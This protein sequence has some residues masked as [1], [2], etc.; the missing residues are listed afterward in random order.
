MFK[1]SVAL[2]LMFSLMFSLAA[3]GAGST[4]ATTTAAG[5]TVAE[6]TTEAEYDGIRLATLKGPTGM[7]MAKLICDYRSQLLSSKVENIIYSEISTISDPTMIVSSLTAG[8]ADIAA[9]PLNLAASLYNKT[10]GG[11][12]MLAINTLGVLYILEK[13]NTIKTIADLKDKTIYATG[14]GSTP[15]YVLNYVLKQNGLTVGED[16]FVEFKAEHSELTALAASGGADICMLPEPNVTTAMTKNKDL[17]VAINMTDEWSAVC[18]KNGV[19]STLAQGCVVATK[20]FIEKHPDDLAT[21]ME[22]YKNSVEY[23]NS[24]DDA[25]ATIV[26]AEIIDN[27]AVAKT[28]IPNCHIT[29]VTGE[30][31]KTIASQNFEVLYSADPKAV[32]GKIPDEGI[33]FAD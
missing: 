14:Q 32:G 12:Q 19:D 22:Q 17:R 10:D 26:R 4:E 33:Y 30:E 18:K 25:A 7:G 20:D 21:F 24:S 29:F 8:Q 23:I 28:A 13:G 1:K 11:I 2:I 5:T 15:E 9:C 16:V 31:M 3:C 6:T 27:E